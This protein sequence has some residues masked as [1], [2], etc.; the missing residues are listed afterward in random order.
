MN[1][2]EA[3]QIVSE[4]NGE[5][6]NEILSI[7]KQNGFPDDLENKLRFQSLHEQD[8]ITG[9]FV[10][11]LPVTITLAGKDHLAQLQEEATDRAEK[12]RQTRLQNQ[13]S[14]ASILV[15]LVV[16]IGGLIVEYYAGLV[17]FFLQL[18]R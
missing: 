9:S 13:L 2:L 17:S 1:E 15:N 8:F 11:G 7:A 10:L 18:F 5:S 12:K 6:I 16:F 14:V 4:H 3:L